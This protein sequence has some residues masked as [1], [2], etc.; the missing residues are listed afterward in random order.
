M[1]GDMSRN[2]TQF[3]FSNKSARDQTRVPSHLLP[4]NGAKPTD[5]DQTDGLSKSQLELTAMRFE[6][7]MN[8]INGGE[9]TSQRTGAC[10]GTGAD[11]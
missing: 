11:G 7:L 4:K 5:A 6:A 8:E 10:E 2:Q 3:S 9:L 1:M